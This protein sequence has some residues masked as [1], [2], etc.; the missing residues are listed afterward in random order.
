VTNYSEEQILGC[1]EWLRPFSGVP[2]PKSNS[3]SIEVMGRA[4]E[5]QGVR[6]ERV[7]RREEKGRKSKR[8]RE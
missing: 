2:M 3:F 4:K 1:I 6:V 7:T 8:K 5:G